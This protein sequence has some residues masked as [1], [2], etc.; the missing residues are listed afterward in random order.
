MKKLVGITVGWL[1]AFLLLGISPLWAQ[2]EAGSYFTI[3]GVVKNKDNKRKLE[4]VN[5]SVSGTNIGTVTNADGVFSLKIKD[6]ETIQG[7]EVSH[8]GYLN[9]QVSL[10]DNKDISDLTIWM[11]QAPNLLSEIVIFGN[12]ARALVEEAIKKIPV[13]YSSD[14]SL[15]TAFYRETVQKGRR[16]ISVSEAVLDVSKTAYTNRTTDYDKLQVLKGR[17]L[18]SQKVS[19]TLAV[20]VMGGPNISVVLDIV[21]NKEALLEPEELNNYEFWMAESALID[22][23]IQYVINFRPRVL[24]PYALF[25]G[26]LYVDCDKLSFTRI[27]MNLDMQNKSKAIAAILHQKPFGLRFKPQELSFLITYKTI[28]G[29]T[30]LNYIRNDIRFKCDWKRRLFSTSYAVTSE[31]VVTDR[32]ESPSEIIPR[33]KVFTSN[34]IFYDKVG[35]YWSEDFWGNYNIIA[36]TESLEHAV[37]K[38][39]KQSN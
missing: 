1:M 32:R 31:M 21:K 16:Y 33:N 35:N 15:L 18:L 27:E 39:K 34:Q 10:K 25:H 20:K 14:K 19:D 36:P 38:L 12:N 37:D 3:T 28:D 4:N 22:N 24:L 7:L 17:R 11:L 29:R 13:N 26:K 6:T 8:I 2:E 23:R 9:S 30:Y 5:V